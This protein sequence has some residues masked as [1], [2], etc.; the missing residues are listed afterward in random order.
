MIGGGNTAAME[1]VFLA[2]FA[3]QVFLVHRGSELRADKVMQ[4]KIF[5]H[6]KI[7]C[8]WNTDV[9]KILGEQSVQ[10]IILHN[11]LNKSDSEF[12]VDGVFIAIGTLPSSHFV[13]ELLELDADGYI[14]CM[15]TQTSCKGVFAAGDVVCDSMKQAIYAAGQGALVSQYV[16][17]YI[18]A[19]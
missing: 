19:R 2:N 10:K 13:E 14:K 11:K 3:E 12:L 9:V 8:I 6:A 5:S 18:G 15:N 1:A 7:K 17:E 16:E 4:E